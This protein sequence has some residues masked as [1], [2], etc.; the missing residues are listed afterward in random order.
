M[1]P[2]PRK[3]FPAKSDADVSAAAHQLI[4]ILSFRTA[5]RLVRWEEAAGNDAWLYHFSRNPGSGR[6]QRSGVFHGLEIIYVFGNGPAG[7]KDVDRQL[8]AD[9]LQRWVNFAATGNPNGKP[10]DPI[11]RPVKPEWPSYHKATNEHL[12]F[13]DTVSVGRNLDAEACDLVDRAAERRG[14]R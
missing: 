10:G 12:D 8:S 4:T 1:P 2:E 11:C 5:R 6:A 14:R 13:G 7:T 9:M 3:L